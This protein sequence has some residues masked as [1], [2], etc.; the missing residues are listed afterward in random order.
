[1]GHY[2]FFFAVILSP[3]GGTRNKKKKKQNKTKTIQKF[4]N[5]H[6]DFK[7]HKHSPKKII[8]SSSS[9]SA[10]SQRSERSKKMVVVVFQMIFSRE[11]L[12]M[13]FNISRLLCV[14]FTAL[15]V[16]GGWRAGV[17]ESLPCVWCTLERGYVDKR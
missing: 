7:K 17:K 4:G 5:L 14:C 6:M 10:R 9:A 12:P 3:L 11:L 15:P 1:M 2:F 13:N 16:R 8:R